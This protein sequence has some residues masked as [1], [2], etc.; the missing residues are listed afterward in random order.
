M[1]S[2]G[3]MRRTASRVRSKARRTARKARLSM[4]GRPRVGLVGFF[5]FG[6]Y[7]DEL[8]VEVYKEHLGPAMD[9]GVLYDR[10]AKPYFDRPVAQAVDAVDAVVIGGGDLVIPWSLSE[11]YWK[12][13]YLRR[14]VFISGVGVPER[15]EGKPHP[16]VVARLKKFFQH[17]NIRYISARDEESCRWI[18]EHLQP[19]VPV[20]RTA[21]IVCSLT[22]PP[23]TPS[24]DVLGVVTRYRP[25]NE[26]DYTQV[27]ALAALA[28]ER[29]MTVRHIV[30]ATGDTGRRDVDNAGTLDVPGKE[31]VYSESLDDLSRAI[32]ECRMLA[33]MKFHGSVVATMYGVPSV[34]MMPT[35]KNRRFFARIGRPELLAHFTSA[36]L[37]GYLDPLPARIDADAVAALRADATATMAGLRDEILR[38]V[39]AW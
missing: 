22:L 24:D 26:D 36:D 34:C 11:L 38:T 21:D 19:R 4:G 1:S 14:P 27:A 31:I 12:R 8:F 3:G 5:D 2:T 17:P 29:G 28:Q 18:E 25:N 35:A 23:A 7:G 32:G 37:V 33:S 6:N 30:L 39:K 10:P 15:A 13:E 16:D 20:R 9:L